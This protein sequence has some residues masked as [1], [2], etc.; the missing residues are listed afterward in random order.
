[1]EGIR[2]AREEEIG[3]MKLDVI[4]R[5]GRKKDFWDLVEILPDYSLPQLLS[6]YE[7]KYPY[8]DL[9]EVKRG[10]VDFTAAEEMPDPICLRSR[11]WEGVKEAILRE[12][13]AM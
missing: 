3:A 7:K 12:A 9:E 8:N 5:G 13:A 4:S 10:L 11:T 2:L 1:M 6:V